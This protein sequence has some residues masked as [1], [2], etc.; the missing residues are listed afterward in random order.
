MINPT[1]Y[2]D[3]DGLTYRIEFYRTKDNINF[4]HYKTVKYLSLGDLFKLRKRI[5]DIISKSQNKRLEALQRL[6]DLDQELG[7]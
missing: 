6:S 7:L 1:I 2:T 4:E 3:N 5:D